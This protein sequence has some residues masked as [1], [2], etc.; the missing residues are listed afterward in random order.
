M[1][2]EMIQPNPNNMKFSFHIHEE[3]KHYK[4]NDGIRKL[5]QT[6]PKDTFNSQFR[7]LF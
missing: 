4:N 1:R 7:Y 5:L 6:K 3:T 2:S